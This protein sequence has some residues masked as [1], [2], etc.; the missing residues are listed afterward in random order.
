MSGALNLDVSAAAGNPWMS[1]VDIYCER[2]DASFWAEPI[3]AVSNI[4]FIIAALLLYRD[5]SKYQEKSSWVLLLIA[6][7]GVIGIG[8]FLFHTFANRWSMMADELP[9]ASFIYLAFALYMRRVFHC[10]MA[11]MAI[12]LVGFTALNYLF[13]ANV[14]A[15]ALNGSVAYGP[16]FMLLIFLALLSRGAGYMSTA[17]S[18]ANAIAIFFVSVA[19]RSFD[20][21]ICD[22]LPIGIHYMWHTLNAVVLYHVVKGLLKANASMQDC[23]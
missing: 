22:K 20:M 21:A 19:M 2:L 11:V 12:G 13:F 7:I 6:M 14:P 17:D 16:A 10:S 18:L 23:K 1:A 8:S 15:S 5:Y 4:F 3:N 9:I